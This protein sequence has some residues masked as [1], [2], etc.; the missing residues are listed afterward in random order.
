MNG[1]ISGSYEPKFEQ[2]L[3]EFIQNF[4]Q[5]DEVGASVCIKIEGETVVDLW[6]GQADP[7]KNKPWDK[8][9]VSIIFSCT[10]AAVAL[11]AHMLIDQG[12][13]ELNTPVTDYW[14]EFGKNGKENITVAMMLNHSAGLPA[15]REPIKKGGFADW[16]YMVHRLEEEAPFWEPGTR[17]G[18]HMI[19]FGWTVGE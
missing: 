16:D 6:G 2:V 19:S 1:E 10:K 18:Y 14:P 11:C 12:K 13:L 5:R 8:D 4:Q 7:R 17:N 9:T 15:F 3:K